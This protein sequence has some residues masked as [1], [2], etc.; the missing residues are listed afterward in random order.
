[1]D[2][3]NILLLLL[4]LIAIALAWYSGYKSQFKIKYFP[5]KNAQNDYFVGLNYLLNDEPDQSIDAFISSLEINSTSLESHLALGDLL[6]R[7]GK[8]D[9]SISVYQK[10]LADSTLNRSELNLIKLGL[11]KS[12]VAAGL[13]DRAE[14]LID[15]LKV[16]DINIQIAALNQGLIVYQLEKE[17]QKAVMMV[18]DLLKLC[19]A[20]KRQKLQAQASH[21]Y[22]E[23]AEN[24]LGFQH[25]N[26]AREYL[27]HAKNMDRNNVRTSLIRG[28]L[29]IEQENYKQ[30]IKA[31]LKISVQDESYK[32]EAFNLLITSYRALNNPKKLQQ[33]VENTL[34]EPLS[35][36]L[37]LMI[38]KF[39]KDNDGE[40]K[41]REILFEKLS[42]NP[43]VELLG[44]A[45]LLNEKTDNDP[46]SKKF[47]MIL[48]DFLD[49]KPK[50]LCNN[51]GFELKKIHWL[52]PSCN[53]WG[54]VKPINSLLK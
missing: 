7:R 42:S 41:A 16:A 32:V 5:Q 38:I 48:E 18:T 40:D 24:E 9:E 3:G 17:W 51:C 33:F 39:I 2:L 6:R 11:V 29:E 30:A 10:L 49:E 22:C 23:L 14:K 53:E 4:M 47:R 27:H 46:I 25:Y 8:V 21:F 36:S 45:I 19:S 28:K 26:Q 12:Y 13:L 52:C 34:Q 54:K 20:N 37:L 44:Q 50:Y 35:S 31:L 15:E 1:M 43:S